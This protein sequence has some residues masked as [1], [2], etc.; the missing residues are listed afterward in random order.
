MRIKT[1]IFIVLTIIIS[2]IILKIYIKKSKNIEEE[3]LKIDQYFYKTD[4]KNYKQLHD[5]FIEKIKIIKYFHNKSFSNKVTMKKLENNIYY[6]SS[7]K[8]N[9]SIP[10]EY[11]ITSDCHGD[12]RSVIFALIWSGAYKYGNESCIIRNIIKKKNVN[13]IKIGKELNYRVL[14]NLVVADK[15]IKIIFN[16]DCIDRGLQSEEVL[17]LLEYLTS[18][19]DNIIY[20]IGNHE[21]FYITDNFNPYANTILIEPDKNLTDNMRK[22]IVKMIE[23]NKIIFCYY[24]NGIVISHAILLKEH[25]SKVI[26]FA[27]SSFD[28][29]IELNNYFKNNYLN[30]QFISPL[31]EERSLNV[32][33]NK[34]SILFK[35]ILGHD[36]IEEYQ[37]FIINETGNLYI[38][39]MQSSGF[40]GVSRPYFIYQQYIHFLK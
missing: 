27:I 10:N 4:E 15:N 22:T 26:N 7:I 20:I 14:P 35:Q 6:T 33:I 3:I 40:F 2:V 8:N 37:T 1:I 9:F 19:S 13:E 30:K 38:D 5:N 28:I 11:V 18:I 17:Y 24:I 32:P 34:E 21:Y 23:T 16:G 39:L 29:V 12:L 36:P 31:L 25:L